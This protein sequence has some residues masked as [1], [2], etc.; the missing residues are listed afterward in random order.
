MVKKKPIVLVLK[1]ISVSPLF[2]E[3]SQLQHLRI[4]TWYFSSVLLIY[5]QLKCKLKAEVKRLFF[6]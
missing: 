3:S 2:L 4:L 6:C 1:E 5:I